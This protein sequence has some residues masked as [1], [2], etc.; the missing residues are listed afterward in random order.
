MDAAA[1]VPF[2]RR[3]AEQGN[4]AAQWALTFGCLMHGWGVEED[5]ALA[6]RYYRMAADQ[7]HGQA[8]LDWPA[9][10][11]TGRASRRTWRGAAELYRLAAENGEAEALTAL[12][13]RY[14]EGRGV[15]MVY[16]RL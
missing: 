9:A 15:E 11:R 5:A 16:R 14:A 10:W 2:Y 12:G 1:A 4:A 7:G 3:S 8:Q 13:V 6:V